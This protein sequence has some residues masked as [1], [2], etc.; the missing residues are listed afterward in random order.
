MYEF[1][2]LKDS[3][4]RSKESDKIKEYFKKNI[5]FRKES[6][7]TIII[8]GVL[9]GTIALSAF[10][11]NTPECMAQSISASMKSSSNTE[12]ASV[13]ESKT[14]VAVDE[15]DIIKQS[16]NT[17][18]ESNYN[19]SLNTSKP[20]TSNTNKAQGSGTTSTIKDSSLS[21][22]TND[23][24]NT[25][26]SE[27][28]VATDTKKEDNAEGNIYIKLNNKGITTSIELE[29]YIVG[30]VAAE[31]PASF[32]VEALKSQAV[33][34]RT[35][36][37]KK[38]SAGKTLVNSTSDQVYNTVDEMKAKWGS[39]FNT[40]YNKIKSAVSSTKG[41][42]I[43][44]NG[45]YIDALYCSMTNGK[46]EQPEYVWAYSYP[47]LKCVSSSWDKNVKGFETVKNLEY[48][49]VS[50]ALGQTV[51]RDTVIEILYYTVSGRVDKIKI[52]DKTYTGVEIRTKLGL[53]STD[54]TIDLNDTN[55]SVTTRGFGHGVGL[56]QYGANE[57]AKQGYTYDKILH[58]YY[59]GI[60]ISKC[61]KL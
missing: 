53:R 19:T 29:E 42:V 44:Y 1:G 31:M 2:S 37:V 23:T 33:A 4:T 3:K 17:N 25:I 10:L 55:I 61:E 8:N 51:T 15:E 14:L 50:K 56:S 13:L 35:Y 24:T 41:L 32:S 21:S 26:V 7:V 28:K 54:F 49:T 43:T 47:Y 59:T 36:T 30:V 46:T 5:A 39:S 18:K 16:V 6:I 12:I 11:A 48:A 45:K 38:A 58:H 57:M 20:A 34:A 52:G 40:Y 27:N 9:I 22:S 60:T